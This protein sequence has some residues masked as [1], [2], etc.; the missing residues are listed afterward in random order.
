MFIAHHKFGIEQPCTIAGADPGFPIG[1]GANPPGGGRQ[2][3]ILPDFLK[4][5]MKFRNI[6]S[7]GEG[8][9]V[10]GTPLDPPLHCV[11]GTNVSSIN[12]CEHSGR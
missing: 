4:N 3:T 7:V 12:K 11:N 8:G 5:C 10:G 9:R 6:W 2:H 1:G